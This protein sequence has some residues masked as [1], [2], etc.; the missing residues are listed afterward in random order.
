MVPHFSST[1]MIVYV[2]V[3][4]LETLICKPLEKQLVADVR[5]TMHLSSPNFF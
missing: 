3:A 4:Y 1:R 5:D 2:W